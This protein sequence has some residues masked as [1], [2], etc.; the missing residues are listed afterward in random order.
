MRGPA[1]ARRQD[2][3]VANHD[4]VADDVR[5]RALAALRQGRFD[6]ADDLLA[7]SDPEVAALIENLRVYQAE[8]EIQNEELL[9]SQRQS[10]ESL[11]RFTAFFNSLPIAEL[12]IDRGGLVKEANLAAQRL[13]KL[14]NTYFHQHFFI[15]LIHEADRGA[16]IGAWSRLPRERQTVDLSEI[17]FNG[18]EAGSFVGDLHLAPLP[19]TEESNPLFVCAI[20]DRTEAV[21]QRLA[22]YETGARLSRSECDLRRSEDF[23]VTTGRMARI[24]GWELDPLTL[25]MRWTHGLQDLLDM[26][27]QQAAT[28]EDTLTF[29]PPEDRGRLRQAIEG[30]ITA[31]ER[32]DIQLGFVTSRGR[33]L[34][35]QVT[36]EPVVQDG[37]ILEL[38]GAIQDISER[39]RA[40]L[41]L[42]Q[43]RNHL[44]ELVSDRTAELAL[45]K[46]EAE[47]ANQA[48][49]AFLANMSH[50]I[51]TPM[52]AILGLTHLLSA[53]ISNPL[54][55]DQL[56]KIGDA[57]NHLLALINDIL[58]ISKIE[59]GKLVLEAVD[60]SPHALFE[61]VRSLNAE[62]VRA[63]GLELVTDAGALP[64]VLN[65]DVTRLRQALVNYLSNAVK[66]TE[67]GRIQL[68][69][70]V[71]DERGD[72]LLARFE[73]L[74]TGIGIA[75]DK[76]SRL[77][78]AF[79]QADGST[80]R[81]YGGTGLG[82]AITRHIAEMMGG[83][84]GVESEPGVGSRFWFTARLG[85]GAQQLVAELEPPPMADV[86]P[87]LAERCRG[88]RVLVVED[89]TI[90]QEVMLALLRQVGL[91]VDLAENGMRAV[92]LAGQVSYRLVLMDM[93]MPE[94]DGLEA[95]RLI[96]RLPGWSDVPILAMTA[97]VFSEDRQ[98]CIDAGMNDHV[99]K[100]V[101]PNR[102]YDALLRWLTQGGCVPAAVVREAV[103]VPRGSDISSDVQ[104]GLLQIPGLDAASGLKCVG[105]KAERYVRLLRRLVDDHGDDLSKLRACLAVGDL[106]GARRIAHTLKGVAGTLGAIR[107]QGA[108]AALEAGILAEYPGGEIE[109]LVDLVEEAQA[110]LAGAL[111]GLA[112]PG[113][114]CVAAQAEALALGD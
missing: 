70:R 99:A 35:L 73:V 27:P 90:N 66:F 15:R 105:G 62:R 6:L 10:Q 58:D 106:T 28:L 80:T 102:L 13:F 83:E 95:T 59:A 86:R 44:E 111:R 91:E 5:D 4:T 17:R 109:R 34:W 40:A 42:E 81:R 65:G 84:V 61:Q 3:E 41:E 47:R 19:L 107:L 93:Q 97:N 77:F 38:V 74:D 96:R 36:C 14:R 69:A 54:H 79:E 76:Q 8:L 110:L 11:E 57:A 72:S 26:D 101:D 104:R 56:Q 55:S 45:A 68:S 88:C 51:R 75:P 39:T 46:Q 30:V 67:R 7:E 22:L 50:E 48:K 64:G 23:L 82:L 16:V 60:F 78:S 92:E 53:E 52:N 89:N 2:T 31:G 108:A 112:D 21:R 87:L 33:A 98:R 20:I 94:M 25:R 1:A 12:V 85:R 37:Q 71:L 100:P 9:R 32:F 103:E 49:S 43:H 18:G 114:S 29:F 63:K 24:V 113:S